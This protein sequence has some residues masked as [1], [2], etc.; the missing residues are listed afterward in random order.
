MV[1]LTFR[2]LGPW[3]AGKAAN[4]EPDEVDNNIWAL[5]QEIFAIQNDPAVPNGIAEITVSGTEMTITLHD[6]TVLG[7]YTL[8][9]LTFRWRGE[10]VAFTSY[11]ELDVVTVTGT[12][13]FMTQIAHT[14]GA[15]FDQNQEIPPGSGLLVWYFLFGAFGAP[16][17][18]VWADHLAVGTAIDPDGGILTGDLSA[19]RLFAN[20]PTGILVID[21]QPA[22]DLPA[23]PV[24]G[25]TLARFVAADG[26]AAA[27]SL[28]GF[29]GVPAV[30]LRAANGVRTAPA[31][32]NLGDILGVLGWRGYGAT[33]FSGT[34]VA[35]IQA[36]ALE[37]FTD[38][39]QG[40][41]LRFW[42]APLGTATAIQQASIGPG[43]TVGAP[44]APAGGMLAGDL[45]AARVL[46]NG[47]AVGSG[48]GGG[49]SD[50]P[51]D[52]T[53][54]GRLNAAW[55]PV[56]PL[57]GG[58]LSGNLVVGTPGLPSG[59]LVN[60]DIDAQRLLIANNAVIPP[61][62]PSFTA[63]LWM[64]GGNGEAYGALLDATANNATLSFRRAN[65]TNASPSHVNVT[66]LLGAITWR[67]YGST[68][69][70][71][72][73]AARLSV[74]ALD[75]FTD[76][77]QGVQYQF[78]GN[79]AG[80]VAL[81]TLAVLGPGFAIGAAT[82]PSDFQLG[83]LVARRLFGTGATAALTLNRN[84]TVLPAAPSGAAILRMA[85]ADGESP[86]ST[87]ETW[88][89]SSA[90]I[91]RRANG[92]AA[93]PV[94]LNSSD[95]IGAIAWRGY[96]TTNY[97][98]GNSARLACFALEGWTDTAQ[99]SQLQLATNA[100]GST[101][102]TTQ[103][104]IGP[105]VVVGAPTPP[106]GG[107]L[108]G[109]LNAT[110]VLVNGVA[111]GTSGAGLPDA[112]VDGTSYGRLNA[113][114]QRVL[115]LTG[116]ALSGALSTTGSL[117]AGAPGA[118]S[119]GLVN[120]DIVGQRGFLNQNA[121]ALPAPSVTTGLQ[122][123]G[124]DGSTY[125]AVLGDAHGA[126]TTLRLR[127][128]NGTAAV[129]TAILNNDTLGQV[130]F[131]GYGATGY[132]AG[133]P[134]VRLSAIATENWNDTLHAALLRIDTSVPGS[135]LTTTQAS[136]GPG[137]TVGA[138]AAPGGGMQTGDV[139]ALR[140]FA[141]GVAVGSAGTGLPLAGGTISG[142]APGYVNIQRGGAPPAIPV[143][144]G[145]VSAMRITGADGEQISVEVEAIGSIPQIA[146]FRFEG[147]AA[148]PSAV[149]INSNIGQISFRGFGSSVY[150]SGYAARIMCLSLENFTNTTQ[151]SQLQFF[152]APVGTTV[153]T[154]QASI[155]PGLTVGTPTAP[156]GGM[157]I[158]DLN[159]VRLLE[160][161]VPRS[162]T[163]GF[164]APSGVLTASQ[165]IGHHALARAVTFPA[166]FAGSY[167]GGTANATASTVLTI[168]KATTGTGSW[169]TIGTITIAAGTITPTFAST[170]GTAQTGNAGDVIRIIGP[171]TFDATFANAYATIV[172]A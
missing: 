50:A 114:W 161:G 33:G 21:H 112:P 146:L 77:A 17:E 168:A 67:G 71:T 12:G 86:A 39:A 166:N 47:V 54:Y 169:T 145:L 89:G 109:D 80:G 27:I 69:Y 20:D 123:N 110:R 150:P 134:G 40:V 58:T 135:G 66:D 91:F 113:A 117:S 46:V 5:A 127:R 131:N 4:L 139:N 106:A 79:V 128:A 11:A 72:G 147:T 2:T 26:E 64:V 43:L 85:G 13:I 14:S 160:N 60:G 159:A 6:G 29:A 132:V 49:I 19:Q 118:P 37:N 30:I 28:E 121:T 130:A 65:G 56:L 88:S 108:V 81:P 107:M 140:L 76:T 25:S 157:Q 62:N 73:A 87:M 70:I 156:A 24:S 92:T 115:P 55:Q 36:L 41:A 144:P 59:G 151:G 126:A 22:D 102:L 137:L 167:A 15:A 99:G 171:A 8:P 63:R 153:P 152:A 9:V 83:D 111:V 105:G 98:A 101:T 7:P 90:H 172:G 120:G 133:P 48:T 154:L 158:G 138:P 162:Y 142:T 74:V 10:W 136:I 84:S 38:A 148:A 44:T 57:T 53:I 32:T 51:S 143:S 100:A 94:A 95:N 170:G 93:A 163:F 61:P 42:T 165:V 141:N 31:Q 52:G 164:S 122:I 129:P 82:L 35:R 45:N 23:A 18:P 34:S 3:G 103:A 155:G 125:D 119:G 78:A 116:G 16:T 96:G 124:A 104:T 1:A 68:G 75:T 149:P 97:S